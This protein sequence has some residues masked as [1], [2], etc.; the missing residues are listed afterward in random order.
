MSIVI[1][2]NS[3]LYQ[4]FA[5]LSADKRIIIVAGLPGVGKSLLVQQ[6]AL[7]AHAT[8]RTVHLLQWD[9]SRMAFETPDVIAKYPEID[10]VTHPAIR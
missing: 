9:V 2:Q 7:I 8:G 6:L 4:L 3:D 10:G 5:R 1:P